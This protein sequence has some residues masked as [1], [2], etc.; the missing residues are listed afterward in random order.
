[1][2]AQEHTIEVSGARAFY[3]DAGLGQEV[4][5]L[6]LHSVPTS[7]DDWTAMLALTG[8]VAV[9]LPGFGRSDKGTE[10]DYSL[11]GY[12]RFVDGLVAALELDRVTLVGHGWGGAIALAFAQR[13][14]ELVARLA[15]IDPV[16]LLDAFSWPPLVRRWRR[17]VIGELM[18]GASSRRLIARSLRQGATTPGAWSEERIDT[19]WSQF[20]Q[21]TQ[22]AILRLHRAAGEAALAAAGADLETVGAPALIVWGERDPWLPVDC[23]D[24]YGRRLPN[25]TVMRVA[26]AGHWPWL[27]DPAVADR[28]AAFVS[29]PG[30]GPGSREGAYA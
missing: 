9:D 17:P 29:G 13:R 30:G 8:G 16:P 25:A 1:V 4:T 18:M 14:P 12:E 2:G 28:I 6:Y 19:I 21:G 15:L 7:C 11:A 23:A 24:A 27:D 22:R 26:D 3:R 5:P 20:D 10:L